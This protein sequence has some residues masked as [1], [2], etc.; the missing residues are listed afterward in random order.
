[1]MRAPALVVS[2]SVAE[3]E[4]DGDV[5]GEVLGHRDAG[6]DG[7][8][9]VGRAEAVEEATLDGA[10]PG[11]GGPAGFGDGVHVAGEGDATPSARITGPPR[12]AT[13]ARLGTRRSSR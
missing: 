10:G 8:L 13:R 5:G 7:A 1:M 4:G 6:G 3:Q 9:H 2:S 12:W 11:V